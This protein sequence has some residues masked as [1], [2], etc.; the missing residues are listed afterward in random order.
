[1]SIDTILALQDIARAEPG[2]I[3]E[4]AGYYAPIDG[5]GGAFRFRAPK[6]GD[7][8]A[9]TISAVTLR[10]HA[11]TGVTNTRPIVAAS[12][13]HG[14]V[15]GDAVLISGNAAAKGSWRVTRIDADHFSLDESPGN[16]VSTR[17]GRVDSTLVT[18]L[19][20][21]G[22]VAGTQVMIAGVLGTP[23][24]NGTWFP[25]G[26]TSATTFTIPCAPSGASMQAAESSV[27]AVSSFRPPR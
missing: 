26:T 5:G 4:V 20:A 6:A 2:Q 21:H 15:T 17:G 16:G 19:D 25:L 12:A 11:I 7:Q 24:L 1:M 3:I 23:D 10:S 14:L 8:N 27:M 13:G 9:L 18:T 22:L